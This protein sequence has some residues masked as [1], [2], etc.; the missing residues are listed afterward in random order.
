MQV[1]VEAPT[2]LERRI[3]VTVPANQLDEAYD[4]RIAKLAKTAKL[5]GFRPGKVPLAYL[6]QHFGESARQDALS[7]VIKTTLYAAIQQENLNP[8]GMPTVEPKA[9]IAGE[10]LEFTAIFEILPEITQVN[11]DVKTLEKQTS[12][13]EDKDVDT[14]I[15]RLKEQHA[16]WKE[17]T[18]P[19]QQ[20]DQ[21][22]IDFRG[23]V[24]GK[25]FPGGEGHGYPVILGSK[26]MIPGFEEGLI[27]LIAGAETVL[28]VTFP[29]KYPS[30]DLAGKAAEFATTVHKVSEPELPTLD[31]ALVKKLG[32][33]SGK[34]DE[35]RDEIKRNL[36]RE[37]E[38]MTKVKLKTQVFDLLL[39]QNT[40]D[41]PK[42]LIEQE[43]QRIH[44]EV[45]PHHGG[46]E[47]NHSAD[48]MVV[49]ED[50]AKRN[51]ALGLL[52]GEFVKQQKLTP[53]KSRM[54][55]YITNL[56]ASYEN[57]SEILQWYASDKR[58]LA[59]IEMHVIEDQVIDKL[60]EGVTVTEKTMNYNELLAG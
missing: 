56:A 20:K 52:V 4:Q 41:I 16:I 42:A 8:V 24:D 47:H 43:A 2:K 36:N 25:L 38:R 6:K 53:D 31:E 1:S 7:D 57:P 40:F 54:E 21:V 50:A 58:R 45:H 37:V 44:D 32:I 17:V 59:E 34:V 11:F 60:L 23:S 3:T 27:G 10:P 14:V 49:F 29:E 26:S 22:V 33:K 19:S 30:K 35:L 39:K 12:T 55:A 15:E 5:K 48:E 28:K 51:V 9:M 46:K 18:R 13:I